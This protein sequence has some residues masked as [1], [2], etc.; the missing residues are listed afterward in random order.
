MI[1]VLLVEDNMGDI[2][3][4]Q[5]AFEAVKVQLNM[6][7]ARDGVEAMSYFHQKLGTANTKL[8]DLVLLDL[9]LPRKNGREVLADI[10]A[11]ERLRH[12]PV[13]ILTTSEAEQDIIK[14]YQIGVNAYVTKPIGLEGLAK[15]VTLMEEFWFTIVKL[16]YCHAKSAANCD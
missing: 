5:D 3:L 7:I 2:E 6:D 13:V 12:I 1:T 14:S 10:R 16:P 8:P 11:D 9:N 15:I 4:V